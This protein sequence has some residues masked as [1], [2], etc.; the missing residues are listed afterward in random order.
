MRVRT[1]SACPAL[2]QEN[3]KNFSQS[4]PKL[5]RAVTK[6]QKALAFELEDATL[7]CQIKCCMAEQYRKSG[8]VTR[9]AN[10]E[11]DIAAT[12][13]SEVIDDTTSATLRILCRIEK[14]KLA[15]ERRDQTEFAAALEP[16]E[17][18]ARALV[19]DR[20]AKMNDGAWPPS[21][22]D[23]AQVR[24]RDVKL[25]GI[26]RFGGTASEMKR[27]I[28][29]ARGFPNGLQPHVEKASIAYSLARYLFSQETDE[30]KLRIAFQV[31]WNGY[32]F[33]KERGFA[34]Q[35]LNGVN[36]IRERGLR[37]P[38]SLGKECEVCKYRVSYRQEEGYHCAAC[39]RATFSFPGP[40]YTS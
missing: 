3:V 25:R 15:L 39:G 5:T 4:V 29:E 23:L 26:A 1:H 35:L 31:W 12:I 14:A 38:Q 20:A 8:D 40:H 33:C 21:L 34:K 36:L 6:S 9:N 11:Y 19:R 32:M 22:S 10:K 28:R 2:R 27:L 17:K 16:A 24:V 37:L 7:L 13:T 18:E 30:R